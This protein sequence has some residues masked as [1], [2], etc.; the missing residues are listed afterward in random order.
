[1][2]NFLK[3][4][5]I[6]AAIL[7]AALS[8]C[9]KEAVIVNANGVLLDQKTLVVRIGTPVK[10]TASVSPYDTSD[11]TLKWTSSNLTVATVS[12]D[13]SISG[14][15]TGTADITVTTTDGA[16]T[17]KCTVTVFPSAGSTITLAG[18]HHQQCYFKI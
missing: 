11:K 4:K 16:F 17:D 1:M 6:L 5:L 13:G 14:V 15:A 9:K 3:N 12:T 18:E 2:K 8:S 10:I 7:L